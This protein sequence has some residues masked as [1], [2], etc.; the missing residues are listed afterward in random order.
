MMIQ[1]IIII[2]K[3]SVINLTLI[4]I[5]INIDIHLY[6]MYLNLVCIV[7]RKFSMYTDMAIHVFNV[8]L[9]DQIEGYV[10]CKTRPF[11]F[12]DV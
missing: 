12:C 5:E 6:P 3:K 7:L 2:I 9:K 11:V 8:S 10:E 4:E 1:R